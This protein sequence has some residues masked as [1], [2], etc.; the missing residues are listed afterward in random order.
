MGFFFISPNLKFCLISDGNVILMFTQSNAPFI[1]KLFKT[2]LVLKN[3]RS[4]IRSKLIPVIRQVYSTRS[5]NLHCAAI[6]YDWNFTTK[7][8]L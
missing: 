1:T 3:L 5:E 7:A 4:N 8:G 6:I 2:Y